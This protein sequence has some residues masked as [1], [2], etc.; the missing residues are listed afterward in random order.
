VAAVGLLLLAGCANVAT[1]SLA[2]AHARA[3]DLAVRSALGA[4]RARL[5]AQLLV[6]SVVLAAAGGAA[7]VLVARLGLGALLSLV[8]SDVPRLDGVAIDGRVLLFAVA[9]SALTALL[10]GT[11]PALRAARPDL[12]EALRQE[13]RSGTD[14]PARQRT[15]RLLVMVEVALASVLVVGSG[16]LGRSF[17]RLASVDLGFRPGHVLV[18]SINLPR[19]ET[20]A[21]R[22]AFH[23]SLLERLAAAPGVEQAALAYDHPLEATWT[24]GFAIAGREDDG[25]F[26]AWMRTVSAGYF[27]TL[28]IDVVA[29]RAFDPSE[30]DQRPGVVMI[31]DAFARRFFPGES[32]IGRRL[33][34]PAPTRPDPPRDYEIIGI[35]GDVRFMGPAAPAEP[36]Y[37]VHLGQSPQWEVKVLARTAGDPT[38]ILGAVRAAVRA[39]DP[40]QPI[41][42]V[43]T[44]DAL[45]GRAL[46]Q[47]RFAMTLV[48]LFGGLA[49]LL[50]AVGIYGLL[51]YTVSQRTREIGVRVALGARPGDLTRLVLGQGLA[52]TL[53]GIAAGLAAAA[54]LSRLVSSLL[55]GVS[56][57][58]P[59]TFA[60]TGAALLLVALAASWVP[61]RRAARVDPIVALRDA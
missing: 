49:F 58:D 57:L 45:T 38:A 11:L 54:A 30:D 40:L 6:E 4:S 8:P 3:R 59:L 29:G 44:L 23:R 19:D 14:T 7:G 1:L 10:F 55:Y 5:V 42:E 46:A 56:P 18:A 13:G 36:A 61:V 21:A 32:P 9:V 16:L 60:A 39:V 15:R 20:R 41:A 35:V 33:I 34:L 26:G 12:Q 27:R 24:D 17:A 43:T 52:V 51:A 2:R 47:P 25:N 53:A 31:N 22:A 50:A 48:G 37:Y 28:G